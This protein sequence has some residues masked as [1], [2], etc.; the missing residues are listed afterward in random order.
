[1]RRWIFVSLFWLLWPLLRDALDEDEQTRIAD[2][3]DEPP[4]LEAS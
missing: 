4:A 3:D 2:G 1:M